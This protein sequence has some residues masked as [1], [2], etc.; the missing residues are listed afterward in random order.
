MLYDKELEDVKSKIEAIG[1]NIVESNKLILKAL[2]NCDSEVFDEAKSKLKNMSGKTNEID[3]GIIKILALYSPEAKDLRQVVSYLKITNELNRA[4]TNTRSFIKGFTEV[5]SSTDV[6]IV[7]E[8][9][10]PMQKSTVIAM[11]NSI[12]MLNMTCEDELR[13]MF[14]DVLIQED[15]T[16]DLYEIVEKNLFD[17]ADGSVEFEKFHNML[18]ALRKSGKIADRAVSIAQLILYINIGG[19]FK[20]K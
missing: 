15:K 16:G 8:Y 1:L 17:Q 4:S 7:K 10:I 14:N 11:Q 18:K 12:S 2:E 5:C 20:L 19:S 3:N 9:A 6:N 13:D